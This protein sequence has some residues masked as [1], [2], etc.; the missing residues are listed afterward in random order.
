MNRVPSIFAEND[1]LIAQ[2]SKK[3]CA[4][5]QNIVL[6]RQS[7]QVLKHCLEVKT[8]FNTDIR[9]FERQEVQLHVLTIRPENIK[10]DFANVECSF[11]Y[12]NNIL[13]VPR[14]FSPVKIEM[15]YIIKAFYQYYCVKSTQGKTSYLGTLIFSRQSS[16]SSDLT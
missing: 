15:N 10:C 13:C 3:L 8:S 9:Y 6:P 16:V 4:L 5:C 2:N 1:F 11:F 14:V 12:S 7:E